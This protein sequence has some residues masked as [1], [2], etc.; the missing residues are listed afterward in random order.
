M[1]CFLVEE[2]IKGL[3]LYILNNLR[4]RVSSFIGSP[5]T[6]L[7]KI[8]ALYYMIVLCCYYHENES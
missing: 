1:P 8:S 3:V 6:E 4:T 2:A 7:N 5:S